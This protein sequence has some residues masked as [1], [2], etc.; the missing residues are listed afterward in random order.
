MP[1]K[2]SIIIVTDTYYPATGGVENAVLE[3][4]NSIRSEYH[5]EI[6]NSSKTNQTSGLF[7]KTVLAPK[8]KEY[9]DP[10]GIKVIPLTPSIGSR[11]LMV[12]IIL[13]NLPLIKRISPKRFYDCLSIF[14]SIALKKKLKRILKKS[15]LVISYSTSFAAIILPKITKKL[16]IPLINAPVIHFGKWGDSYAQIKSYGQSNL[17]LCPTKHFQSTLDSYYRN[18]IPCKSIVIPHLI[19]D[20]Q[21]K[22]KIPKTN[23]E[24]NNFILF[25]GRREK[26]K[27]LNYLILA[28]LNSDLKIPLVIAG[29]GGKT[30]YTG[31]IIDLGKVSEP[32]K[33][34]LLRNCRFLAVPSKDESFGIVFLEAMSHKKPSV[35]LNVAPINEILT[36][37]ITALLSEPEDV[38]TL[39]RNLQLLS[40]DIDLL[41]DLSENCRKEFKERFS[42]ARILIEYFRIIKQVINGL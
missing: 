8:F 42:N 35:A 2:K 27:G 10:N 1:N 12:P 28:Y 30:S 24:P 41:K 39:S 15:D 13:W 31:N 20:K 38:F 37:N 23:L 26:H 33:E 6:L 11:I 18:G 25:I 32:E 17:I 5:V 19:K 36:H 40:E 9:T 4:A 21:N 14:Y 22:F 34:W 3:L 7:K 16:N 29:P